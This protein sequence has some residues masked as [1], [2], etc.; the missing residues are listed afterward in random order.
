MECNKDEARRA[1]DIA[2]KKLS[3]KDYVGAKKFVD[4]AQNLYPKLDTL[5]QVLM[6]INVYMIASNKNNGGGESDWYGV[7]GVDPIADDEAVKKQYKKLA[8]LL[9][10]DKNKYKGAE[11]AFKL[12]PPNSHKPASTSANQNEGG[13]SNGGAKGNNPAGGTQKPQNPP[14]T[15]SSNGNQNA[16][17]NPSAGS[18]SNRPAPGPAAISGVPNGVILHVALVS[19]LAIH[20]Q[21]LIAE[22]PQFKH[23]KDRKEVLRRW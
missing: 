14:K 11:G 20:L 17:G 7:L 12:K 13:N 21:V 18:R 3:E 2:E 15:A 10:P 9:H 23:K 5:E 8:L 1:M 19:T 6:M 22:M 4:K 16:G